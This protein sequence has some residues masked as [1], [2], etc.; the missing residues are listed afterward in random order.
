MTVRRSF[1]VHLRPEIHAKAKSYCQ[2]HHLK[3]AEWVHSL[4]GRELRI[5]ERKGKL[6]NAPRAYDEPW[7]RPPFWE[8]LGQDDES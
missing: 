6:A 5:I 1:V 7:Q 8:E 3:M 2:N 4:I